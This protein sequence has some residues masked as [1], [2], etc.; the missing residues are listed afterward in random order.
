MRFYWSP[1]TPFSRFRL[2]PIPFCSPLLQATEPKM[3]LVYSNVNKDVSFIQL[4]YYTGRVS[5]SNVNKDLSST[6]EGWGFTHKE[7][8]L[9]MPTNSWSIDK[10]LSFYPMSR[11]LNIGGVSE[12]ASHSNF[13]VNKDMSRYPI[14][15]N[16]QGN[17]RDSFLINL[18]TKIHHLSHEQGLEHMGELKGNHSDSLI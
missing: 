14:S 12:E 5:Y 15:R 2:L 11:V 13:N 8:R 3:E 1:T 4:A 7:S 18:W 10:G 16:S 17:W 9:G 6:W